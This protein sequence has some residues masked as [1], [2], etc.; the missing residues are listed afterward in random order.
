M[1]KRIA[2]AVAKRVDEEA[3]RIKEQLRLA[4]AALAPSGGMSERKEM[5]PAEKARRIEELVKQRVDAE[6]SRLTN[7]RPSAA[8]APSPNATASAP[9]TAAVAFAA[10]PV[11]V[12]MPVSAA[13]HGGGKESPEFSIFEIGA[14]PGPLGLVLFL[15]TIR[16]AMG[17]GRTLSVYCCI[18]KE[19]KTAAA[20]KPGDVLMSVGDHTLLV[21]EFQ[22]PLGQGLVEACVK[23][24]TTAPNPRRIRFYRSGS[25]D[26]AG[27]ESTL[28]PEE[29]ERV[30]P[31]IFN[32][33]DGS[34]RLLEALEIASLTAPLPTPAP[35]PA[36][37]PVP[38]P[39]AAAGPAPL[40]FVGSPTPGSPG[41]VKKGGLLQNHI[42]PPAG[43]ERQ[44]G[45]TGPYGFNGEA[46]PKA[47]SSGAGAVKPLGTSAAKG[48]GEVL[49]GAE[50]RRRMQQRADAGVKVLEHL[51]RDTKPGK[52]TGLDIAPVMLGMDAAP[53][54]AQVFWAGMVVANR[55]EATRITP[56]DIVVYVGGS[57]CLVDIKQ[58]RTGMEFTRA[59][60]ETIA[61][62]PAPRAVRFVR[63]TDTDLGPGEEPLPFYQLNA[64]DSSLVSNFVFSGESDR[65]RSMASLLSQ[66]AAAASAEE[67]VEPL[68]AK[69]RA[70]REAIEAK[71]PRDAHTTRLPLARSLTHQPLPLAR[72]LPPH[73]K[74]GAA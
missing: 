55:S 7:Q 56:G 9:A 3:R 42:A 31:E 14:P 41:D 61:S 48:E 38:V 44:H 29:A 50:R 59:I 1:Q 66:V 65:G 53:G 30:A 62:A 63:L 18:V 58:A 72:S 19:S 67:A 25:V 43:F 6:L 69:Q 54:R 52:P 26:V 11:P 57:L 10:S 16:L 34:K 39:L 40:S 4:G 71:V 24:L 5:S 2:D 12:S 8:L 27:D 22:A 33:G 23:V 32:G 13:A 74:K 17:P 73:P 68:L 36:P 64:E 28:S 35:V 21:D 37:V 15:H 20:I 60:R 45:I 70:Q 46:A 47:S 49:T 51:F